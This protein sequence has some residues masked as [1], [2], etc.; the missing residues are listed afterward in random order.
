MEGGARLEFDNFLGQTRV[1]TTLTSLFYDDVV[2]NGGFI[3]GGAFTTAV[4]ALKDQGKLR[5]DEILAVNVDFGS[6][7]SSFI[8]GEVR[9][10]RGLFG[11]GVTVGLRVQW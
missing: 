9:G 1:T 11:S 2:V 6:G 4:N 8:Q 3:L 10:G 7:V 5:V